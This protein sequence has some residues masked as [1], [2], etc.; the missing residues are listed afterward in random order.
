[1]SP[2]TYLA[3]FVLRFVYD[4][5]ADD[6]SRPIGWRGVIRHVQSDAECQFTHW[7]EAEAFIAQ[8]VS[9]NET[10]GIPAASI[11]PT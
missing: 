4:A 3:S 2:D 9:L 7:P 5:S 6:A 8:Y 1:M 11:P 10:R